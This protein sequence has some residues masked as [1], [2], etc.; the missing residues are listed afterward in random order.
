MTLLYPAF[1][2]LFIPLALLWYYRPRTVT[3]TVH[4]IILALLL[5][6]LARPVASQRAHKSEIEARDLI[7]ALDVSYSMQAGD[8]APTRYEYAKR[9][10]ERLLEENRKDNIMLIAFTTNPLLLSPPTTDHALISVAMESLDP[11]N[12]LTHGTSLEKLFKRVASLPTREK[13]LILLSDGGEEKD[14]DKLS[15]IIR[16]GEIRLTTLALGTTTGTTI[17]KEDG[18]LLKDSEGDL[19]VSRINPLLERLAAS[20]DGNYIAAPSTPRS[21]AEAIEE[22]LKELSDLHNKIDKMEYDAVE[23]YPLP[24]LLAL[25]LFL[26]LHTRGVK[27]LLLAASLWG[28]W[29]NASI[30]DDYYLHR[31]Y[32]AYRT[33]DYNGTERYLEKITLPSLQ[34]RMAKAN[35]FYKQKRYKRALS[36]YR[37]IRS[38]SPMIK[39]RLYYNI[40]NCYARIK[41][42]DKAVRYY[43]KTLQLGDDADARYNLKL[44]LFKRSAAEEKLSFARPASQSGA[45][46]KEEAEKGDEHRKKHREQQNSGGG[47]GGGQTK[48]KTDKKISLMQSD[49]EKK[50]PLGSRVYDLI[51]KGY[52]HEKE[53]W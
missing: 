47:G 36:L 40:A 14:L 25:L 30:F 24:L 48:S 3:D 23:L 52:V 8:I 44:L 31:A 4:L 33:G 5:S 39:Q 34:S 11:K 49:V 21:A 38:T 41:A 46:G 43:S 15:G 1:L 19:V 12:I 18:S 28:G 29:L 35:T 53:P 27:Y 9:T 50:Q 2:W 10:I 7:I 42:F 26:L 16:K 37:S 6:A 45:S 20:V 17:E 51:N 32:E 13:N 22:S